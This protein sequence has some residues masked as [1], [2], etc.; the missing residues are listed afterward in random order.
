MRACGTAPGGICRRRSRTRHPADSE[1]AQ[2]TDRR[3]DQARSSSVRAP[4]T[5]SSQLGIEAR[6][7]FGPR[8]ELA[9]PVVDLPPQSARAAVPG[10]SSVRLRLGQQ[11]GASRRPAPGP[12]GAAAAAARVRRRRGLAFAASTAE[13]LEQV[14]RLAERR[15]RLVGALDRGARGGR[16]RRGRRRARVGERLEVRRR[17]E[18]AVVGLVERERAAVEARLVGVGA[19]GAQAGDEPALQLALLRQRGR[20]GVQRMQRL[21]ARLEPP[22]CVVVDG[23]GRE[24]ELDDPAAFLVLPARPSFAVRAELRE[25]VADDAAERR[26]VV[27]RVDF[28]RRV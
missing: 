15:R 19:D 22:A 27:G 14:G 10:F 26:G 23:V 28:D 13:R 1:Q 16:A 3:G 5:I 8:D 20:L 24:L 11:A 4:N 18:V 6:P 7:F 9:G 21:L 2:R 12:A 17:V 25:P